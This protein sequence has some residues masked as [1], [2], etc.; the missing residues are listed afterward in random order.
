MRAPYDRSSDTQSVSDERN[1]GSETETE[2]R[3]VIYST[4]DSGAI[5]KSTTKYIP[6]SDTMRYLYVSTEYGTHLFVV[7]EI[8]MFGKP[9]TQ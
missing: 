9:I 1:H 6:I 4:A 2:E 5:A 8:R 3:T 7:N